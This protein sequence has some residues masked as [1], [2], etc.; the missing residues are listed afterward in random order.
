MYLISNLTRVFNQTFGNTLC[1]GSNTGT[2][3]IFV[4]HANIYSTVKISNQPKPI[5]ICTFERIVVLLLLN[6]KTTFKP[7]INFIRIFVT[8]LCDKIMLAQ[9]N[10]PRHI[11]PAVPSVTQNDTDVQGIKPV[12]Y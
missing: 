5:S 7:V 8:L 4:K 9:H 3:M 10:V 2:N 1:Y 12:V 11:I 6:I